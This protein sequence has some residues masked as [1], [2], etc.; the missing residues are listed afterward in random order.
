MSLVFQANSSKLKQHSTL[1]LFHLLFI[2]MV[3]HTPP[4]L[5]RSGI[6][7]PSDL[8]TMSIPLQLDSPKIGKG[9][10]DH[11]GVILHFLCP[12]DSSTLKIQDGLFSTLSQG[13]KNS[14]DYFLRGKGLFISAGFVEVI[15]YLQSSQIEIIE[16]ANKEEKEIKLKFMNPY[17]TLPDIE[18]IFS[19]HWMEFECRRFKGLDSHKGKGKDKKGVF[20][21][22]IIL[23]G[24]T[25]SDSSYVKLNSID[26]FEDPSIDPKFF[27]NP[28]DVERLLKAVKLILFMIQRMNLEGWEV[29]PADIPGFD[30]K[31]G[32]YDFEGMEGLEKRGNFYDFDQIP[33]D[34]SFALAL[35]SLKLEKSG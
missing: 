1:F 10:A 21:V 24:P 14:L 28:E 15:S 30:W 20:G 7:P 35:G 5:L 12:Y 4:I 8:S 22:F 29:E 27:Q 16:D 23:S 32:E 31:K 13:I 6:G 17:T 26:P 2:Q 34:V 25:K 3:S 33:D 18:V 19:T 9:L 11:I